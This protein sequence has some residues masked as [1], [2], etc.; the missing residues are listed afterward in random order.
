MKVRDFRGDAGKQG[1][2]NLGPRRAVGTTVTG[3]KGEVN[4]LPEHWPAETSA[5]CDYCR[6]PFADFLLRSRRSHA[7]PRAARPSEVY[8][9]RNGDVKGKGWRPLVRSQLTTLADTLAFPATTS[10]N[11]PPIMAREIGCGVANKE[12]FA[13]M[14]DMTGGESN[15]RSRSTLVVGRVSPG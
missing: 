14:P 12:I 3:G 4:M 10:P 15:L 9:L 1:S 2:L 11:Q 13:T 5:P 6:Y 7:A 8:A